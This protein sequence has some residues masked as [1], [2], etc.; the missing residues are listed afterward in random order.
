MD[1]HRVSGRGVSGQVLSKLDQVTSL[2]D[3]VSQELQPPQ[4]GCRQARC[5]CV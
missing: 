4:A 2:M 5:V 3:E 1:R